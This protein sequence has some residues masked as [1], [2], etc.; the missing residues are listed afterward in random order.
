M[1][2][3]LQRLLAKISV[4]VLQKYRFRPLVIDTLGNI[5]FLHDSF[6][7]QYPPTLSVLQRSMTQSAFIRL[8][9]TSHV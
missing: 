5:M 2:R 9:M 6:S 1:V 7:V 4:I 8:A 3:F